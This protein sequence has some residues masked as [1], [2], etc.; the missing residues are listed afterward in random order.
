MTHIQEEQTVVHNDEKQVM[1]DDRI[2][3]LLSLY[4]HH[5]H[6]CYYYYYYYYTHTHTHKGK[7]VMGVYK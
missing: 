3:C 2:E 5:P 7:N 1:G 6:Y 4:H